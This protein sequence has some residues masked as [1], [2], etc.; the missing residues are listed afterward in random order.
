MTRLREDASPGKAAPIDFVVAARNA[1]RDVM[2]D[3]A[4]KAAAERGIAL[5]IPADEDDLAARFLCVAIKMT[6]KSLPHLPIG[7]RAPAGE[8][9]KKLAQSLDI[10]ARVFSAVE[11]SAAAA[12]KTAPD[13][14]NGPENVRYESDHPS[15]EN[16]RVE[17]S[18]ARE[19]RELEPEDVPYRPGVDLKPPE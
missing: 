10:A 11:G 3:E 15:T 6:L 8:A 5:E 4:R 7:S 18:P 16:D 13:L 19:R 2:N 12:P 14:W 17:P 9:L 1:G